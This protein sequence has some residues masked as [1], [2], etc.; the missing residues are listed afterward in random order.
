VM[1]PLP[2]VFWLVN[3]L[4]KPKSLSRTKSTPKLSLKV[5]AKLRRSPR[6][7]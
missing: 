1:V 3:S 6:K 5:G 7:F 2:S 4:E